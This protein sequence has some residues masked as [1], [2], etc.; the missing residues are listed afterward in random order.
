MFHLSIIATR[1]HYRN[2]I[3]LFYLT[4]TLSLPFNSFAQDTLKLLTWNVQM[5]PSIAKAGGK[6]DRAKA[7]VNQL[8]DR[9]YDVLVFQELFHKRS[10][11]IIS[12]GLAKKAS[13]Y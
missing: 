2:R 7:I 13:H 11:R 12:N 3:I 5:L 1:C 6:A 4:I 8:N 9:D 10:R